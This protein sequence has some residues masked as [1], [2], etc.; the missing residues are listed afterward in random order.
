M[1]ARNRRGIVFD[2]YF[3]EKAF[4]KARSHFED[5]A[6]RGLEGLGFLVGS[7]F[8]H[9]GRKYVVVDDYVT[10]ENDASPVSVR[11]SRRAFVEL[12]KQLGGKNGGFNKIIV[13]WC[14]SHPGYGCFLSSVDV[15]TQKAFF[16]EEFHIAV[17]CDPLKKEWRAFRLSKTPESEYDE[18]S[19]AV[20]KKKEKPSVKKRVF[21]W[22]SWR[23]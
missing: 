18:V 9:A 22:F 16:P 4:E 10:A 17:V 8:S 20:I 19:F 1:C 23:K 5:H 11:F 2:V 3:Q 15:R 6:S 21:K 12:S 13:G 7:V 14:H